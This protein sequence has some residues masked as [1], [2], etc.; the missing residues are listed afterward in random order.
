MVLHEGHRD[1]EHTRFD[2]GSKTGQ[3]V[4]SEP[5]GVCNSL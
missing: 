1:P 5:E 2:L 3:K 4:P